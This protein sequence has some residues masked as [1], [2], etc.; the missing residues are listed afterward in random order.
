M[1]RPSYLGFWLKGQQKAN[2]IMNV[3]LNLWALFL[4]LTWIQGEG[5]E[6][7]DNYSFFFFSFNNK[8]SDCGKIIQLTIGIYEE[9][10][11]TQSY[12]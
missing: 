10:H 11:T 6:E 9:A 3:S 7:R 8:S 1:A 5:R 12:G 2:S 4:S